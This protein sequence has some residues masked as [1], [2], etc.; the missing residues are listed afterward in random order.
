MVWQNLRLINYFMRRV[1]PN[2]STVFLST[3]SRAQELCLYFKQFG[4]KALTNEEMD[5][6]GT[7]MDEDLV[8]VTISGEWEAFELIGKR[9]DFLMKETEASRQAKIETSRDVSPLGAA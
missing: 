5:E 8:K 2:L 4:A 3:E 9:D 1:F 7:P 6:D